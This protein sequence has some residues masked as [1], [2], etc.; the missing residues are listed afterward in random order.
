VRGAGTGRLTYHTPLTRADFT[1]YHTPLTSAASLRCTCSPLP[2]LSKGALSSCNP[3]APSSL[4]SPCSLPL[5][6]LVRLAPPPPVPP[7]L[8][9]PAVP[10]RPLPLGH[11]PPLPPPS[12]PPPLL[13]WHFFWAART[14]HARRRAPSSCR[15]R[16]EARSWLCRIHR[17]RALCGDWNLASSQYLARNRFQAPKP[18]HVSL[19]APVLL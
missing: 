19:S 9:S 1:T 12:P 14:T 11:P 4:P 18:C 17:T 3:P 2:S 5:C 10:E 15:A 13:L 7:G 16:R 6:S 8:S